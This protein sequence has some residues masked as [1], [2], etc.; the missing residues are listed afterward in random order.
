MRRS[1]CFADKRL[2]VCALRVPLRLRTP[3]LRAARG[4]D[5]YNDVSDGGNLW[6]RTEQGP[7]GQPT[8]AR[9]ILGLLDRTRPAG[10]HKDSLFFGFRKLG[11]SFMR[12]HIVGGHG[13]CEAVTQGYLPPRGVIPRALI[14]LLCF[15]WEVMF[16]W[17]WNR[18]VQYGRR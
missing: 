15:S 13:P 6:Y 17:S 14:L 8:L 1:F 7:R 2:C 10:F 11:P 5:E 18:C 3:T 4:D 12:A 16:D 9:W